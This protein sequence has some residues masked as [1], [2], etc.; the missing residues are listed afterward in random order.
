MSCCIVHL[1]VNLDFWDYTVHSII[2]YSDQLNLKPLSTQP[3]Q[4]VTVLSYI[5][6]L[7]KHW[8]PTVFLES[9]ATPFYLKPSIPF[10][11]QKPSYAHQYMGTTQSNLFLFLMHK[12]WLFSCKYESAENICHL[13]LAKRQLIEKKMGN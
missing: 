9:R 7:I 11:S 6:Q 3:S 10:T 12:T 4:K 1:K 5:T 8:R 13:K 2:S